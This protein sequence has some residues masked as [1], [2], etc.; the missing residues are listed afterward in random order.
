MNNT[1]NIFAQAYNEG[2]FSCAEYNEGCEA[3]TTGS[4]TSPTS[5]TTGFAA[6]GTGLAL[7]IVCAVVL[8]ALVAVVTV[9]I[10]KSRRK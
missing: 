5:P 8:A 4:T 1:W 6:S 9:R 3:Q 7:T 2:A 10:V